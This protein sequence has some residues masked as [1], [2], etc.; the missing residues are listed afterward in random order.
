MYIIIIRHRLKIYALIKNLIIVKKK[1]H[2]NMRNDGKENM[3]IIYFNLCM[4]KYICKINI[5]RYSKPLV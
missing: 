5:S 4:Q 3:Y 1:S 2:I